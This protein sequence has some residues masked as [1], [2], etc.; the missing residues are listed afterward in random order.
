VSVSKRSE[1]E[2]FAAYRKVAFHKRVVREPR[3]AHDSL[4][5]TF[6]A[7]MF[8][9]ISLCVFLNDVGFY[10]DEAFRGHEARPLIIIVSQ[11][12]ERFA[13]SE[14]DDSP[15]RHVVN[16]AKPPKNFFRDAKGSGYHAS[17]VAF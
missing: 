5:V 1:N 3:S 14:P 7:L 10:K 4:T 11:E 9:A 12:D 6:N 8:I 2:N 16:M 13:R 17:L 15:H